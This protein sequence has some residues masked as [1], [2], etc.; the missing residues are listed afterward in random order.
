[1]RK[2]FTKHTL[3]NGIDVYLYRDKNLKRMV[4]SYNVFYGFDGF[5]NNF[6]YEG[7][8][9]EVPYAMAHF[10][11]HTLIEKSRFG[12]MLLNFKDL[13]YD[14]NG[15]TYPDITSYYFVGI[16]DTLESLKK[17]ILMVDKPVFTEE[18]VED[19]KSAILEEVAKNDN[20]PY[21]IGHNLNK[22]N[23]YSSFEKIAKSNNSLGSIES[24]KSITYENAKLCYDAFYNDENKFLCIGGS[25][26]IDEM[27]DYLE[28]IY[29]EIE[30][31]P[32]RL[33]LESFEEDDIRNGYEEIELPISENF[34]IISYKMKNVFKESKLFINL[35]LNI[36]FRLKFGNETEFVSELIK[37]GIVIGGI[38]GGASLYR[39]DIIFT[40]CADVKDKDRFIRAIEDE[41]KNPQIDESLFELIKKTL[42]VNELNKLDYIY[43][44]ILRFPIDINYSDKLYDM[45]V[46]DKCNIEKL[47]SIIGRLDFNKKTVTLLKKKAN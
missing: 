23:L 26:E 33:E 19:V 4:A 7:K 40:F 37:K 12:N 15:S 38:G 35:A 29:K 34:C 3:S 14:F 9:R 5:Y 6:T 45:D 17:L 25:F 11:E 30:Y 16:K 36:F 18:D 21:K 47:K 2:D 22:R 8:M 1:M 24:T 41:L 44:A 28:S 20:E 10:L 31:H 13:N 46:L 43:R 27:I 32:N 39:D 42:K